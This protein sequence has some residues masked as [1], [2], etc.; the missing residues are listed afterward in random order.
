V[1][2]AR[3]ELSLGDRGLLTNWCSHRKSQL[4]IEYCRRL[5][6]RSPE[7][8]VFWVHA[9]NIDRAEQGY[10]EI[11][12][13]VKIPGRNDPQQNIFE[14]VARWLRDRSKARWLL[15]LDNADDDAVL[16]TPQAAASKAQTSGADSQLRRPLSAY[17]PQSENGAILIT[18]R[19]RSV[20]T[21]L[22]EPR[23]VIVVDPMID[24]DAISLLKKK[25]DE[26]ARDGDLK[27]LVNMSENMP[28]AIVQAAAYIQQKGPR[29]SVAQ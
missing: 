1:S 10:R 20:A 22:V 29:Y 18:T 4:A 28:L 2:V 23:D 15:V 5:R 3:G 19:T 11:A 13:Q 24:T 17:L 26:P 8:W 16:L 6:E 27:A 21:M 14:L 12:E 25:L 7:R 9:S